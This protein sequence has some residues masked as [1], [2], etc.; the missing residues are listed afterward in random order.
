M[1]AELKEKWVAALRS[2]EYAQTK[3]VLRDKEGFC[4]LG[5]LCDVAQPDGWS[6]G[7]NGCDDPD[8][9]CGDDESGCFFHMFGD[10]AEGIGD[11][12]LSP[13]F[14]DREGLSEGHMRELAEYNDQGMSFSDL[15]AIIEEEVKVT[16]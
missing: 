6:D 9:N 14:L 3:G 15:A 13:E 12:V 16:A 1:Q 2:G 11:T 5:V 7:N 8:C 10:Q 4:C